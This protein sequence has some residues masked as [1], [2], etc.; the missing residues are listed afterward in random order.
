[1]RILMINKFLYPNGGSETYIFKLGE[2]LQKMGHE[3]QFFGMQHEG[4]IVGNAVNAYTSDMDFHGGS[5]LSMISNAIKTIYSK[6]ARVQIRKVLDDFAPDVCH[7]NNFNYQLTPSIILEIVKWRKEAD[8]D[9]KIIY[10]AH[11][12]Q[13]VCPNHMLYNPN[14]KTPCEKCLGGNYLNCLKGKCVHGSTAKSAIAM[15]ESVYWHKINKAY[16]YIDKIICCSEFMKRELDTN[17]ILAEKT[18]ALHN[19]IDAVESKDVEKKEYVLYFGSFTETKGFKTMV[20]ACKKLPDVK[21]VFAGKG[22]LAN[23]LDGIENAENVGFKNGV[24]LQNLIK[25]AKFSVVPSELAEN[26]PFTVLESQQLGTP[27]IGADIGGIPE[28]ISV[29]EDGLLFKSGDVDS[30]I[31]AIRAL[32]YDESRLKNCIKNCHKIKRDSLNDYTEKIVL[33]YSRGGGYC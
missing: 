13:F 21:F 19:F 3:V 11:D 8:K 5:K 15:I 27:V 2:Q 33:C 9:C 12:G 4:N 26:C 32:Y 14:T 18:V 7:L 29:G 16:K 23:L 28:L 10:T 24:E 22:E 31:S 30:L 17:P 6:E 1:M 25:E 20:E